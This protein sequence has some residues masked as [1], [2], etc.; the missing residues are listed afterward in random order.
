MSDNTLNDYRS[1]TIITGHREGICE[2][3]LLLNF[4]GAPIRR[5]EK[6]NPVQHVRPACAIV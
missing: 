1:P 2:A 4:L 3:P 6:R 5:P